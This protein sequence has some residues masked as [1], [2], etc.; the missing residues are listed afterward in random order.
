MPTSDQRER[1]DLGELRTGDPRHSQG[2]ARRPRETDEAVASAWDDRMGVVREACHDI[3]GRLRRDGMLAPGWSK[4]EA[5]DLLWAMLSI[6]TWENLTLELGWS[7]DLYVKN[8][9]E[10]ARRA[11]V[12]EPKRA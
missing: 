10:L 12:R 5:G 8:M 4:E 7:V 9:Q 2:D 6:G 11:F 3:V 1:A